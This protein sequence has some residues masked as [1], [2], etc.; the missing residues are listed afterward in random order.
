LRWRTPVDWPVLLLVL[1]GIVSYLVSA[2]RHL[3][4]PQLLW[5]GSGIGSVYALF[6]WAT[7]LQRLRS[8]VAL[9]LLLGLA[10]ALASPVIVNWSATPPRLIPS[11]I[12][13]LFPLLV[14]NAVHPNVMASALVILLPLPLALACRPGWPDRPIRLL[15]LAGWLAMAAAL[16]LTESRGGY[17]ATAVTICLV[18]WLSGR[19]KWAVGA[20]TAVILGIIGF[21]SVDSQTTSSATDPAN[22]YFRQQIWRIGLQMQADFPFTGVGM[23]SFNAVAERLYPLYTPNNPGAHNLF[24]QVGLD[25]GLPGLIAYLSILLTALT[26][27][28]QLF[29]KFQQTEPFLAATAVGLL[30]SL[31][32]L[33]LHGLVDGTVWGTRGAALPWLIIGL[34]LALLRLANLRPPAQQTDGTTANQRSQST[35]EKS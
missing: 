22:W 15:L 10:L 24:L 35:P 11:Q 9:L 32:G 31:I 8:V 1:M 19:R 18:L 28:W 16:V 17:L 27:A 5:L 20:A 26:A 21:T 3:T 7:N 4:L 25:L 34:A 13:Q 6:W 14:S 12:Y 29:R 23:G 33:I 30:A 2:D